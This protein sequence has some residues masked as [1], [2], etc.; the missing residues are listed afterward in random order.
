[1]SYIGE[2]SNIK[3]HLIFPILFNRNSLGMII[4]NKQG[5]RR[6]LLPFLKPLVSSPSFSQ[7]SCPSFRRHSAFNAIASITTKN[8]IIPIW[9]SNTAVSLIK[10]YISKSMFHFYIWIPTIMTIA[11]VSALNQ[12]CQ[13]PTSWPSI[14]LDQIFRG[15]NAKLL[16][17]SPHQIRSFF[18]GS[19][20]SLCRIFRGLATHWASLI[21]K[22]SNASFRFMIF[23]Y[24]KPPSLIYPTTIRTL[25]S[26]QISLFKDWISSLHLVYIIHPV[27]IGVQR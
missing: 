8:E 5:L 3:G 21:I 6:F 25:A 20:L 2:S 9:P 17:F 4:G 1:M 10:A 12:I 27:S 14:K 15:S 22:R 19:V 7:P 13:F 26:N 23:F 24:T 18:K 16:C 11:L